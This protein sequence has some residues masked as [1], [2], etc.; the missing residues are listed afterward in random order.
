MLQLPTLSS[1][2]EPSVGQAS[3]QVDKYKGDGSLKTEAEKK[4]KV[5]SYLKCFLFAFF[6]FK[7]ILAYESD[8]SPTLV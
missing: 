3:D 8:Y 4:K 5:C 6:F 1:L 7:E 2:H